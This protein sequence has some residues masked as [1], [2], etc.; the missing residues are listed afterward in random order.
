MVLRIKGAMIKLHNA[1]MGVGEAIM[2]PDLTTSQKERLSKAQEII[3]DV[4]NRL[5]DQS[6][7]I[8][9][10]PKRR[11]KGRKSNSWRRF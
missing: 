9:D 7:L 10:P 6:G 5:E 8:Y 2:S 3:N 11:V 1:Y 4:L